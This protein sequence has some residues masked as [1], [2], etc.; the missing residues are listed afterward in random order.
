MPVHAC[1]C[2]VRGGDVRVEDVPEVRAAASTKDH[3]DEKA[4]RKIAPDLDEDARG[5]VDV[6]VE[7]SASADLLVVGS[8]GLHGLKALGSVSER[9]A[10]Q[11]RCS[12][13]VVR[14][15]HDG[16]GRVRPERG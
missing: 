5:A 10:N 12:V 1:D 16:V 8:R 2:H 9:V 7:A 6:L 3:L 4:A 13:I 11:A 15:T 14:P